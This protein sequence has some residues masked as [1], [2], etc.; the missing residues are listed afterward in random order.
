MHI[1]LIAGALGLTVVRLRPSACRRLYATS[2]P[3]GLALQGLID[4][5]TVYDA[6]ATLI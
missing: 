1:R 3:L 5:R 2:R 6:L 4:L